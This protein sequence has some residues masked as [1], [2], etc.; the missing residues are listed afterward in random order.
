MSNKILYIVIGISILLGIAATFTSKFTPVAQAPTATTTPE[1]FCTADA[2]QC[3]DGSY[4]GRTGPNCEFVC[5]EVTTLPA[6]IQAA[7][8]A[9][10]DTIVI[11]Q[12]KPGSVINTPLQV[13]G[14]ARGNWFFEASAPVVL[15]NW[16]G[17]VV[18][19]GIIR[20]N[21]EWMTT[22]FV[23]FSGQLTFVSPYKVGDQ[24]FMKRGTLLF[25]KD[26]PSGLPKN[27]DSLQ[28]PVMFGK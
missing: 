13:S 11:E 28:I 4:V 27:D 3:P 6:N 1:A 23:P 16:D 7:I 10:A 12:P 8:D 22:E 2:M 14:K 21:G 24:D 5:P 18:A 9:K 15:T 25:K 19:E 20:A 17:Q 26:N